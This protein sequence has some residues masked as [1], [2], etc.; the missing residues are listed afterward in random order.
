MD[1]TSKNSQFPQ[2]LLQ[3]FLCEIPKCLPNMY[4][5]NSIADSDIILSPSEKQAGWNKKVSDLLEV[6]VEARGIF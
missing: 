2:E 5:L 3:N 6:I 4:S 1:F